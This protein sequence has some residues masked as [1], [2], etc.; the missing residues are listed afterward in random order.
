MPD[1]GPVP[2]TRL[3]VPDRSAP[4]LAWDGA[5]MPSIEAADLA[6][7]RL[8]LR[9]I[10]V[11]A[12]AGR[13]EEARE[14]IAELLFGF[15]PLIAARRDLRSRVIDLLIRCNA[16]S[17]LRRFMTALHGDDPVEPET[18]TRMRPR[19]AASPKAPRPEVARRRAEAMA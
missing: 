6:L 17:L 8:E 1:S 15:Q 13:A 18:V 5:R 10:A 4:L 2:T 19:T 7:V 11:L 9:E 14:A 12:A 16:T 3:D